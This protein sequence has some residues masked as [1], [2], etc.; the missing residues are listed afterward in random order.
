MESRD[1]DELETIRKRKVELEVQIKRY[2]ERLVE[3]T[4]TEKERDKLKVKIEKYK[5]SLTEHQV[6]VCE[7]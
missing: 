1:G 5:V 3:A 4:A 6:R 7:K 2:E